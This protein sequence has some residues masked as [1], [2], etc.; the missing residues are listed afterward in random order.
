MDFLPLE[1]REQIF[2][3]LLSR[4]NLE[5]LVALLVSTKSERTDI[6]NLRLTSK[7]IYEGTLQSF[8]NIVQDI[9]TDCKEESLNNLAALV[10]LPEVCSTMTCLA[11]NTCMLFFLG[12]QVGCNAEIDLRATWLQGK[13]HTALV[14]IIQKAPRLQ[15]VVCILEGIRDFN[16]NTL[17]TTNAVNAVW[18][19]AVETLK[20]VQVSSFNFP[21]ACRSLNSCL[22]TFAEWL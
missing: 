4:Q 14:S 6:Y 3:H 20:P 15:S 11:L 21:T 8:V 9:P 5:K 16:L 18:D 10:G 17:D 19:R 2:S 22:C 7:R 12:S 13:L 1:L